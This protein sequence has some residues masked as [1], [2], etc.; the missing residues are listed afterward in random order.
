ME[1]V[2]Q[3]G[4]QQPRNTD[5]KEDDVSGSVLTGESR[6]KTRRAPPL[7]PLRSPIF[8]RN[9]GDRGGEE[10]GKNGDKSAAH[11][12]GRGI[13]QAPCSRARSTEN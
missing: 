13:A 10:G 1:Y 3:K 11:V 7:G 8:T 6:D 5:R 12:S 9:P 4:Q 2:K